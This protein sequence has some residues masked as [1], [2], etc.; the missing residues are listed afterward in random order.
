MARE[1][2]DQRH[3]ALHPLEDEPV[4]AFK[5]ACEQLEQRVERGFVHGLHLIDTR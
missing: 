1:L 4:D 2:R 5:V 3:R